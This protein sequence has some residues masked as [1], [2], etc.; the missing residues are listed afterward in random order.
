MRICHYNFLADRLKKTALRKSRSNRQ[1]PL[2]TQRTRICAEWMLQLTGVDV[3]RCPRCGAPLE[4]D[5]IR[6]HRPPQRQTP[7]P[8]TSGTRHD[9]RQPQSLAP[10]SLLAFRPP[11]T[12]TAPQ[13]PN[14]PEHAPRS[15]RFGTPSPAPRHSR[16]FSRP[17]P[18][19]PGPARRYNSQVAATLRA[20]AQFKD[21]LSTM[22]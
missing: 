1:L 22:A 12:I 5:D 7:T 2:R 20:A 14:T 10:S 21:V 15:S 9:P 8:M 6:P 11:R 17:T 18:S 4:T 13:R 3:T 16:H 19:R